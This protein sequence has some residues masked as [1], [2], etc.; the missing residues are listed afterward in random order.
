[1]QLGILCLVLFGWPSIV[2]RYFE[3]WLPMRL[4]MIVCVA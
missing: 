2:L 1:M 3:C 4:I